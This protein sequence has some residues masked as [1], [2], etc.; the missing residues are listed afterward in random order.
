[1][2]ECGE[3]PPGS[4]LIITN[5]HPEEDIL[6]PDDPAYIEKRV[7]FYEHCCPILWKIFEISLVSVLNKVFKG[8][9]II[10]THL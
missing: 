5:V 10:Y 3:L 2:L 9:R 7:L 4:E 8:F 6:H 1:M